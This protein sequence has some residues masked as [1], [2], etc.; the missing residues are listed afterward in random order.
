MEADKAAG[1]EE[2]KFPATEQLDVIHPYSGFW[3]HAFGSLRLERASRGAGRKG[4][5]DFSTVLDPLDAFYLARKLQL[6]CGLINARNVMQVRGELRAMERSGKWRRRSPFGTTR[7]S[8]STPPST[9]RSRNRDP[10]HFQRLKELV[11]QWSGRF[12]VAQQEEFYR[13]LKNYCV[14][15]INTGASAFIGELF[16]IYQ[17]YLANGTARRDRAGS[18]RVQE[19]RDDRLAPEGNTDWVAHSLTVN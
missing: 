18:R 3:Q 6:A 2:L 14:K 11:S 1:Y 8:R 9:I 5:L 17:L 19:H 13:Y 4:E 15:Q 7:R 10:P 12:S 16:G